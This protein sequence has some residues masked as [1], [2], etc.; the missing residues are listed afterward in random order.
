MPI[1]TNYGIH[2]HHPLNPILKTQFE[3]PDFM[4][5]I[6]QS[7]SIAASQCLQGFSEEE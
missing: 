7:L 2:S 6:K 3:A 1:Q 5:S 4:G